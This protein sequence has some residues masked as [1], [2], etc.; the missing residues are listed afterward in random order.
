MKSI[1]HCQH[2]TIV[3][4]VKKKNKIKNWKKKRKILKINNDNVIKYEKQIW[5]LSNL[6]TSFYFISIL[7]FISNF[8]WIRL[9]LKEILAYKCSSIDSFSLSSS[10]ILLLLSFCSSNKKKKVKSYNT[11]CQVTTTGALFLQLTDTIFFFFFL[12]HS[13]MPHATSNMCK[14]RKKKIKK[15]VVTI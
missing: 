12:Q 4:I 13:F 9:F 5:K 14:V 7:H 10:M 11:R 3:K 15:P 6:N 8:Y 1:A 2:V